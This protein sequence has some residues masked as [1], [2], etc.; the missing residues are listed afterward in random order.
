MGWGGEAERAIEWGERGIRLSPFDPWLLAPL[1]GMFLGHFLRG[2]YED[3]AIA[4][5]RSIRSKPGH[6]I[7]YMLLAA[8]L[9]K[10]GRADEARA[11]TARLLEL[12]P[13][14]SIGGQCTAVGAVPALAEALTEAL[15]A[16]GLPD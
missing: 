1:H 7:S 11:A 14:F 2:R 13:N 9:V 6:S 3:T 4:V 15:R 8:A 16:V 10:L 12:Q 5:R